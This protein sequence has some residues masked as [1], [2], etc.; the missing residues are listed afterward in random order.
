[1]TNIKAPIDFKLSNGCH[2]AV[3]QKEESMANEKHQLSISFRKRGRYDSTY[4][5]FWPLFWIFLPRLLST[6]GSI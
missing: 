4:A 5:L 2:I 1:M 3:I 6:S